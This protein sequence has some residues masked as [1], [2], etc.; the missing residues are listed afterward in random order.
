MLQ[1]MEHV[2]AQQTDPIAKV[3]VAL[4][5]KMYRGQQE[6]ALEFAQSFKQPPYDRSDGQALL[7]LR[8]ATTSPPLTPLPP[9]AVTT[10]PRHA[11]LAGGDRGIDPQFGGMQT[12]LSPSSTIYD[13]AS[14]QYG[15]P[16]NPSTPQLS[17]MHNTMHGQ[18]VGQLHPQ[19]SMNTLQ[20]P[21]T[22]GKEDPVP[23]YPGEHVPPLA[24]QP[25]ISFGDGGSIKSKDKMLNTDGQSHNS[26]I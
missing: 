11:P 1:V 19:A 10:Q 26:R 17:S 12:P 20:M 24:R 15:R 22:P 13:S 9:P 5:T 18:P 3:R 25:K 14:S 2:E 21:M 23:P 16:L 6:S 8:P 4:M 7:P